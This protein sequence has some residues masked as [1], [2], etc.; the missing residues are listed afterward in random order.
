MSRKYIYFLFFLIINIKIAKFSKPT[1]NYLNEIAFSP[2]FEKI[3]EN[4]FYI[5]NTLCLGGTS[6]VI[7]ADNVHRGLMGKWTFDDVYAIDY[8]SNNNHMHKFIRPAPGFN[9]HGYSAAFL[10]DMSGFVPASDTL[11][12]TE[13]TIIFWIY[14]L[15]QSTSHFRNIISQIDRE[16]EKIEILL[17]PY[18]TR[19]SIKIIGENNSNEG[20]SSIGYIPLRRWTNV[21][22]KL[23]EK[24][25]E[26]YINGIFDNSVY[27]KN[28]NKE[29][30]GDIH[31]GKNS[32]YSSFN[33]YIDELYYYNRNLNISEIKSFLVPS[34]TGIS[35][36]EFVYVG[37]YS[38]DYKVAMSISL[39]KDNYRLCSS[40][41]FYNG[42]I[43]YAR[44]NGIISE[45]S[46]LW[47]LDISPDFFQKGE[48]RIA[49][50]C[51]VYNHS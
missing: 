51:K 8:S 48:K 2:Q 5:P 32:K 28:N 40:T 47:S 41:D 25:I 21:A 23:S 16:E 36:T 7:S 42:V 12:S 34:V 46:N 17:H 50:C 9:G 18:I 26:I 3:F 38:C 35:N 43:H 49:L 4:C 29:K 19:L 37:H 10:G 30:K 24:N 14:L 1:F 45:K 20:L 22:I 6:S 15:E 13:F 33:G 44:V 27:L 39:C 31:V 11:K